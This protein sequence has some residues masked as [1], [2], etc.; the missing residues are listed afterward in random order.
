MGFL[1]T[2]KSEPGRAW[3]Q[4]EI[5]LHEQTSGAAFA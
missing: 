3:N 4:Y 5:Y 1:N 2:E